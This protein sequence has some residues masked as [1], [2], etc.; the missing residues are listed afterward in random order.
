MNKK[1]LLQFGLAFVLIY[2]GVASFIHPL[3]WIGFVPSWIGKFGVSREL[4][5]HLHAAGEIA[6]GAWLLSN[7]KIRWAGWLAAADMVVII[8][9]NG[10]GAGIFLITF[11]DVGLLFMALYL[12]VA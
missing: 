8:L 10:L 3:D 1:Y 7:W 11:R 12:A 5:L 2:A 6:L 4:A 9:A